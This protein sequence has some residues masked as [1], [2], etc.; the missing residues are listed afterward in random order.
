M[1]TFN[2]K[3]KKELRIDLI[4]NTSIILFIM[5]LSSCDRYEKIERIILTIFAIIFYHI[6]ISKLIKNYL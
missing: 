3:E 4:K 5:S 1:I 6:F 2:E